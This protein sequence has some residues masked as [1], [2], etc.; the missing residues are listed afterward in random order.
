MY[1]YTVSAL[2][3]DAQKRL[4]RRE[5]GPHTAAPMV[6]F[7]DRR[8]EALGRKYP[9]LRI[10]LSAKVMSIPE[11]SETCRSERDSISTASDYRSSFVNALPNLGT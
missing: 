5:A 6:V 10:I 7:R 4:E 3:L 2:S 11:L 8:C 1:L 9:T